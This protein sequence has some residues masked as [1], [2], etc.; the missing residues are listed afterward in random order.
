MHNVTMTVI[1][2]MHANYNCTLRSR[3]TLVTCKKWIQ[4][5]KIAVAQ[6]SIGGDQHSQ[7]VS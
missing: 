7:V 2:L 4:F 1:N 5:T 6:W 3:H